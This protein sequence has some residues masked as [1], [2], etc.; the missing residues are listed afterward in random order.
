MFLTKSFFYSAAALGSAHGMHTDAIT[1]VGIDA[2]PFLV[3][4]DSVA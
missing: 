1:S 3:I 4:F 2:I